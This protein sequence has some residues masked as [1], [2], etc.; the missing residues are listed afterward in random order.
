MEFTNSE[1]Y[2]R[3][4]TFNSSIPNRITARENGWLEFKESFN[5][6]SKD[7]Y[8][9]SIAAFANSKGG[10]I[11]FGVKNSPRELIGLQ[12]NNFEDTDE[13]KITGYL[14]SVLSPEIE[15]E[16]FTISMNN[17]TVG[18]FKVLPSKN[19]PTV[20]IKNDGDLRE[21]EIY[22][23]YNAK[24]EKIKF[25]ELKIL[26]DQI[27][28]EE[29]KSWM[30]HLERISKVGPVN[31]AILDIVG[32]EISGRGGTLVI[33]KKLVPKLK[34]I[35]E[36]NFQEGGRPVLKLVG[37]VKPVSVVVGKR[38][39]KSIATA[40][41]VQ[42][43][44]D[45]NAPVVRLEEKDLKKKYPLDYR[46]L[47]KNL[48]ARYKDFKGNQKYHKI[49]K[50]FIDDK[51]YCFTRHLDPDNPKSARKDFYSPSI[52]REFDKHYKKK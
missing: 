11:V 10:Y 50:Q 17:K 49:K 30:E 3:I 33:D 39:E 7:K 28:E 6:L 2:K 12:S 5:W 27:R 15:Y 32:G 45:P 16:K 36:G 42:I 20:C 21:A 9:K 13:A 14:N 34:F 51:R 38:G 52:Y 46:T 26:L 48:H 19:K 8:A 37:D 35:R 47:T 23:R 29:R 18:I 25:P 4:F 24:S 31:A 41:G 43:T 40:S 1:S 22:Y 44:D